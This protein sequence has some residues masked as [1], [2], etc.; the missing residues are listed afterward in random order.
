MNPVHSEIYRAQAQRYAQLVSHE[1][2]QHNILP[3]INEIS[4]LDGL[5]VVEFGAGTGRLTTLLA[6]VVKFIH[7]FDRSRPMMEVAAVN[8]VQSG[9]QNWQVQVADHR[10]IPLEN[11]MA[12]L[13]I[14]GWSICYLVE[15]H[16]L[17]WKKELEKVLTEM[18]R[19]L[20]PAGKIILLETLGTGFRKPEPPAHLLLYFKVLESR[21]FQRRWIRTDYLFENLEIA[22]DL[23]RF[24][25]GEE[26]IQKIEKCGQGFLLPECTGL[27]SFPE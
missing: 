13:L 9:H 1:D 5:T 6:P 20:R 7:A 8:L 11:G 2:H 27:W 19:L 25:F 12:D 22:N 23:T 14:S 16:P 10:K 26:L 18:Q 15:D 4:P 21:G 3:A 24:F 17:H